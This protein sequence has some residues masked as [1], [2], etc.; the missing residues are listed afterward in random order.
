MTG[1]IKRFMNWAAALLA[2]RGVLQRLQE[3]KVFQ[4]KESIK[5]KKEIY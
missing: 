3:R 1:F 2:S 5:K 4:G